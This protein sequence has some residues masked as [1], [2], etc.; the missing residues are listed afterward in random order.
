MLTN[1]HSKHTLLMHFV[2][3]ENIPFYPDWCWSETL[4]DWTVTD[5][6]KLHYKYTAED[7]TYKLVSKAHVVHYGHF[8]FGRQLCHN[9]INVYWKQ[10]LHI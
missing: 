8:C 3:D 6:V 10:I 5:L 4:N 2:I 1:V 9:C 7:I